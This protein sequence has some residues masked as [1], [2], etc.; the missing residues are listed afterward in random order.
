MRNREEGGGLRSIWVI[1][2]EVGDESRR[3]RYERVLGDV[4]YLTRDLRD[5]IEERE[6]IKIREM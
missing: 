3:E 1:G 4:K 2:Y 5:R 6:R